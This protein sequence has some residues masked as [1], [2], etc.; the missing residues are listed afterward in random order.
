MG[1]CTKK[2]EMYGIQTLP[3]ETAPSSFA[4][5]NVMC[6]L[7][8]VYRFVGL[9]NT[10]MASMPVFGV[11]NSRQ[12]SDLLC[13]RNALRNLT[14]VHIWL[15]YYSQYTLAVMV[16]CLCVQN[17]EYRMKIRQFRLQLLYSNRSAPCDLSPPCGYFAFC[18]QFNLSAA[19]SNR[20]WV[21]VFPQG[22]AS[23][24]KLAS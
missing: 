23:W 24:S 4:L 19:P 11:W 20:L 8:V 13:I 17:N 10:F 7:F 14:I 1:T 18:S 9:F 3:A 5:S 22:G 2:T 6:L 16:Q 12:I 21:A 15:L